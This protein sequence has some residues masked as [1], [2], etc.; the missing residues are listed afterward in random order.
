M[1]GTPTAP[2]MPRP[3]PAVSTIPSDPVRGSRSLT[4]P[5]IVGKKNAMPQAKTVATASADHR[6]CTKLRR[7]KPVPVRMAAI[8]SMPVGARRSTKCVASRRRTTI[9]PL[10]Q[11][12]TRMP[13]MPTASS[14]AGTH[15]IGPSSIDVVM[16]IIASSRRNSGLVSV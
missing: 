3:I 2:A 6:P 14:T 15:R 7:N 10:I 9:H 4:S 16:A 13:W 1:S 12:S 5:T 11:T 8:S